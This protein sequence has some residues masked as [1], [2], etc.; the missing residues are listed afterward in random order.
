MSDGEE[1]R[2]RDVRMP[3]VAR[4]SRPGPGLMDLSLSAT[5]L[6]VIPKH[7]PRTPWRRARV[8]YARTNALKAASQ[9][10]DKHP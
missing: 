4:P 3:R 5:E 1:A 6:F 7:L 10:P 2:L 9:T 8:R